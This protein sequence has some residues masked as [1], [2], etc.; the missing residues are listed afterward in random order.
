MTSSNPKPIP[1]DHSEKSVIQPVSTIE[2]YTAHRDDA[3]ASS[4]TATT[5]LLTNKMRRKKKAPKKRHVK[6]DVAI[7][8]SEALVTSSQTSKQPSELVT[9]SNRDVMLEPTSSA[10]FQNSTDED[11]TAVFTESGSGEPPGGTLLDLFQT[12][13][14]DREKQ[15]KHLVTVQCNDPGS[16]TPI[17][18]RVLL[19]K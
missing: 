3:T 2:S 17:V 18:R 5:S 1:A 13:D 19:R 11:F 8:S 15:D 14:F 9:R 12:Y 4:K 10:A 16:N 6:K 7:T